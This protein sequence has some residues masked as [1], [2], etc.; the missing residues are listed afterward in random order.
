MGILDS[1]K[2]I[3]GVK[4]VEKNRPTLP[5]T[6]LDKSKPLGPYNFPTFSYAMF[7]IYG[8]RTDAAGLKHPVQWEEKLPIGQ[9]IRMEKYPGITITRCERAVGGPRLI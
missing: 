5:A 9:R 2:I 6:G 1:Q 7:R 3:T 8:Y 4:P